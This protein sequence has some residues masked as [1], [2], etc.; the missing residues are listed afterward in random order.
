[1]ETHA[2]LVI[3][4][5]LEAADIPEILKKE[6]AD[7]RHFIVP[8]LGVAEARK[9]KELANERS[10]Q[11]GGQSFVIV[12]SSLTSEA[13]NALLKL[14]E[15]PPTE[16]TFYLIVPSESGLLPTLRSRLFT[17]AERNAPTKSQEADQFLSASY[18]ERLEQVATLAKKDPDALKEL[19]RDLGS[20]LNPKWSREAKASLLL[21]ERYVYNRGASKKMLLEELALS[22]PVQ[23]S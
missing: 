15:E 9:L 22:L 23:N 1:M 2:R 5:S 20:S 3:A 8:S 18:K 6:T 21:A 17:S 4:R 7:T 19:V 14:F 16:T 12:T 13:Q 11:S 10:F